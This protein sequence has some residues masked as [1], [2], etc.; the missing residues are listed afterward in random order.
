MHLAISR[1][2][3]A[4]ASAVLM[5]GCAMGTVPSSRPAGTAPATG[6]TSR[7]T[8]SGS[9][10]SSAPRSSSV[11]S[12]PRCGVPPLRASTATVE[13]AAGSRYLTIRLTNGGSSPCR[14]VGYPGVS[15]VARDRRSQLGAAA[16]RDTSV[17]S[18]GITLP[19]QGNTTFVL[20]V[21]QA[22]NYPATTCQPQDA[23]GYRIYPPGSRTALL[24][25]D[26]D[27]TGCARPAVQLMVV[28]PVGSPAL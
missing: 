12:V 27:L 1:F 24:L 8:T 4:A 16:D 21:T 3:G 2:T 26:P 15:I 13:G 10:S 20:R 18:A 5:A 17:R 14:M 9:S 7:T 25:A 19:P 23:Y 28:R 6:S 22:L 11:H